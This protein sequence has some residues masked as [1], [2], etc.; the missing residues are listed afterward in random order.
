MAKVG[1]REA[2][3]MVGK[4]HKTLYNHIATGRVSATKNHDGKLEIDTSELI[5]V[6]GAL[7]P[8]QNKIT[9]DYT[10]P[11]TQ[12]YTSE[13]LAKIDT[14]ITNQEK[15]DKRIQEL[16]DTVTNLTHR[17]EHKP[18]VKAV[19][20]PPSKP[21]TPGKAKTNKGNVTSFADLLARHNIK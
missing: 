16:T 19:E 15:A 5:R 17:L 11:I 20:P 6:Y 2:A 1:I 10:A 18:T 9:Q 13:L 7:Q 4:S 21:Q 8:P 14:L 12:D 3:Q